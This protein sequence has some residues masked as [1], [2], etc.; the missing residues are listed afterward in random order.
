M[1]CHESI[2]GFYTMINGLEEYNKKSCY[3][4][5]GPC[6]IK[7]LCIEN[8]TYIE[9]QE[10]AS[11]IK[12][13]EIDFNWRPIENKT[14]IYH[15]MKY[16]VIRECHHKWEDNYY[17][18]SDN[19]VYRKKCLSGGY[20]THTIYVKKKY[21][22]VSMVYEGVIIR[23]EGVCRC[24][25]CYGSKLNEHLQLFKDDPTVC[26]RCGYHC[27]NGSHNSHVLGTGQSIGN[28]SLLFPDNMTTP[29]LSC[30]CA[31]CIIRYYPINLGKLIGYG[32][33]TNINSIIDDTV[34]DLY[35]T[36]L[37]RSIV[38]DYQHI[39]REHYVNYYVT[40]D[41]CKQFHHMIKGSS[42]IK[43]TNCLCCNGICHR[44]TENILKTSEMSRVS[45]D[46][47]CPS[48]KKCRVCY[49]VYCLRLHTPVVKLTKWFFFEDVIGTWE[50]YY[51]NM[52]DILRRVNKTI[53]RIYPNLLD[54]HKKIIER[55][56]SNEGMK[57]DL[58][59][60]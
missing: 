45:L 32:C 1:K 23:G 37:Y 7:E 20:E 43:L 58:S 8:I 15:D 40:C 60:Y 56:N 34:D 48:N 5:A 53:Y 35:E 16:N 39:L 21:Y 14:F 59:S 52:V 18:L 3:A 27:H 31:N 55:V 33:A 17:T 49:C 46:V 28:K 10:S 26:Y 47:L 9:P 44:G 4:C 2:D 42:E 11:Y 24:I 51:K 50:L 38:V 13:D 54:V 36:R 57:L 22:L 12:E 25:K 29:C 30:A 6:H 19:N 41:T